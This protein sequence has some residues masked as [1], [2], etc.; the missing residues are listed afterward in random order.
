MLAVN[1]AL[2]DRYADAWR[3]GDVQAAMDCYTS[4]VTLH[5]PA[6]AV[7]GA[8]RM[9]RGKSAVVGTVLTAFAAL[10]EGAEMVVE[11]MLFSDRGAA[12]FATE[13]TQLEDGSFTWG[14][15][16]YYALRGGKIA[17]ISVYV[18]D[19]TAL[20]RFLAARMRRAS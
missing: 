18:D 6:T 19:Q 13:T 20:E 10:G 17:S 14:W 8:V 2:M 1:R 15:A 4:D 3:T 7:A 12:M 9:V 16:V 11:D 5:L